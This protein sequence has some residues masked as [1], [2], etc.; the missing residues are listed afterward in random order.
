MRIRI[1]GCSGSGKT[2]LAE[3][4]SERYGVP[5]YDLDDLVWDNDAGEYGVRTVPEKR[6]AM[7][8]ELTARRDWIIEGVYYAWCAE[9]F[10]QA[11]E[12]YL[13]DLPLRVCRRRIILRFLRRRLGLEPGKRETLRSLREL[14]DW[15]ERFSKKNLPEIRAL[16]SDCAGKVTVLHTKAEIDRVIG[17]SGK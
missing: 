13:L 4:L 16:L 7:L 10:R 1:V 11:D 12:V 5:H 8:A 14:L 3:K 2:Y 17:E 6:D 15:T 9:T